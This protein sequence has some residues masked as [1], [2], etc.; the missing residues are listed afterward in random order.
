MTHKAVKLVKIKHTIYTKYRRS[1]SCLF[2]SCQ[3]SRKRYQKIKTCFERKLAENIK[4]DT[5]LFYACER[6]RCKTKARVGQIVDA[7]EPIISSP[8]W[9]R[10]SSYFSSFFTK[11]DEWQ[12]CKGRKR[13]IF[14]CV[15]NRTRFAMFW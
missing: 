4:T 10:S 3:G 15:Q 13:N 7:D 12:I 14:F 6:S 9:R 2:K 11:E 8:Q 1:T 5:K